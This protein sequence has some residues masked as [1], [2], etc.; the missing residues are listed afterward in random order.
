MNMM[1]VTDD[2]I[3]KF[4]KAAIGKE[5]A[6]SAK[7]MQLMMDFKTRM[8]D[9]LLARAQKMED[10]D[11][12]LTNR[13]DEFIA[14]QIVHVSEAHPEQGEI[15]NEAIVNYADIK[16]KVKDSLL[17]YYPTIDSSYHLKSRQDVLNQ[18][19]ALGRSNHSH[20]S[21]WRTIESSQKANRSNMV[22]RSLN[23]LTLVDDDT[24]ERFD[25]LPEEEKHFVLYNLY[26][27]EHKNMFNAVHAIKT[28]TQFINQLRKE[29]D[30][31]EIN[32]ELLSVPTQQQSFQAHGFSD[33]KQ[34]KGRFKVSVE[35]SEQ[36]MEDFLL[37]RNKV[38]HKNPLPGERTAVD[39]IADEVDKKV[40]TIKPNRPKFRLKRQ[41][42]QNDLEKEATIDRVN[43][44]PEKIESTK[45]WLKNSQIIS[46]INRH[47]LPTVAI[48]TAGLVGVTALHGATGGLS[49]AVL[50]V[51]AGSMITKYNVVGQIK[52]A[53][54]RKVQEAKQSVK[55][56]FYEM[57]DE[58]NEFSM[59]LRNVMKTGYERL[60][61]FA[62]NFNSAFRVH[63]E[64]KLREYDQEASLTDATNDTSQVIQKPDLKQNIFRRIYHK[65]PEQTTDRL[66]DEVQ[67][68]KRRVAR[69]ES[70]QDENDG[71]KQEN[72]ELKDL[73]TVLTSKL[74]NGEGLVKQEK[75]AIVLP[76][77]QEVDKE[78]DMR[79]EKNMTNQLNNSNNQQHTIQV[80]PVYKTVDTV[81]SPANVEDWV[82]IDQLN[83]KVDI[84]KENNKEEKRWNL[85]ELLIADGKEKLNDEDFRSALLT[86][87]DE[88]YR[89]GLAQRLE[90]QEDVRQF[91][92]Q[93]YIQQK[94]LDGE[95]VFE[96]DLN[97]MSVEKETEKEMDDLYY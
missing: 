55:N 54:L 40:E 46:F 76:K 94:E 84:I 77:K 87:V 38:E 70:I 10:V 39:I 72:K 15:K 83:S 91:A 60:S 20:F 23:G 80:E 57:K 69:L 52:E 14:N 4:T 34:T 1:I 73:V 12:Y 66:Y 49:T 51:Y 2:L 96:D 6:L 68:M 35:R 19:N 7:E 45:E 67:E 22:L 88:K 82:H 17:D 85:R 58:L 86:T 16:S 9:S 62:R 79:D 30:L 65:V 63:T 44:R 28:N 21:I 92:K 31:P 71:L 13:L 29:Y 41:Y 81:A 95:V 42:L 36:L 48:A 75:E 32:R 97:E 89:D 43:R 59:P 8:I 53:A 64:D 56:G 27:N 3:R 5:D 33:V 18:M 25:K 93:W 61:R 47:K 26:K 11:D 90:E 50:G 78:V 74:V 24:K 37:Y